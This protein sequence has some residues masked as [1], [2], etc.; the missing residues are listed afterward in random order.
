LEVGKRKGGQGQWRSYRPR[1]KFSKPGTTKKQ[2]YPAKV[3]VLLWERGRSAVFHWPREKEKRKGKHFHALAKITARGGTLRETWGKEG[4][5]SALSS[6]HS[7]KGRL[8]FI[9]GSGGAQ[10]KERRKT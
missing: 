6:A 3:D 5:E 4:K 7:G 1:G 2:P 9:L 8:H 10:A